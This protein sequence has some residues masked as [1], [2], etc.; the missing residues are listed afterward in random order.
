MTR[1]AYLAPVTAV[2]LL[3]A[4][5]AD[6]RMDAAAPGADSAAAAVE[7]GAADALPDAAA[8]PP[9]DSTGAAFR[10]IMRFAA[11]SGLAERPYGEII[12][13]V[14]RQLLRRP[15][16]AGMLDM[17]ED[18]R[19][20]TDLT[21]F[22]CVLY[23][24]NVLALARGIALGDTTYAG[25]VANVERL[26]YRGGEMDGYCSRLHYF[27]DWIEDNE[28]R[29]NVRDVTQEAGGVAYDKT[30]N[31]MST[32]RAS[33]PRLVASDEVY[34]CIQNTESDLRDHDLYYI[35]ED[36]IAAAYD[37]LQPGD[38]IATATNIGGLDVTHTGFVYRTES[39]GTA[40]LNASTSGEV[41]IT[42]DLATYV[43]GV[44]AQTGIIVAR[45]VDPRTEL[46]TER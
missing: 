41:K 19:L 16:V 25:Y 28:R 4:C 33:Y 26:R 45:P 1:L 12:S 5:T 27:T 29:G 2:A 34:A 13:A 31:F 37:E 6:G 14:G 17:T 36:D 24:E 44:R 18:E 30:V 15:Y 42:P 10:R 35:P 32:H 9:D 22:D 40:F 21:A 11:D 38:I 46:R 8:A 39:G 7:T 20:I 23:V 3:L 43:Q